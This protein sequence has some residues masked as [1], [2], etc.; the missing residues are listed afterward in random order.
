MW[1]RIICL[2]VWM[3]ALNQQAHAQRPFPSPNH[4]DKSEDECAS[5]LKPADKCVD[6][7]GGD[8]TWIV[9][10]ASMVYAGQRWV[11]CWIIHDLGVS[12]NV[13]A[14]NYGSVG[15]SFQGYVL[16][17]GRQLYDVEVCAGP[18]KTCILGSVRMT[19]IGD[20]KAVKD[21]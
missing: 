16:I 5:V 11:E 19:P 15:G 13:G 8:S 14:G 21:E 10:L 4:P 6:S 20:C 3:V 9:P 2:L 7:G 12:G 17:K 18:K 1:W